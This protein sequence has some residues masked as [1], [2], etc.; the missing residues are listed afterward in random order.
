MNICVPKSHLTDLGNKNPI[1]H[2]AISLKKNEAQISNI[3]LSFLKIDLFFIRSFV[4][5]Y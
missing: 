4:P 5:L 1:T 2:K 3:F